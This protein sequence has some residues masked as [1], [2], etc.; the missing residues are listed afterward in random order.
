MNELSPSDPE[1]TKVLSSYYDLVKKSI[2]RQD[3]EEFIGGLP[4]TLLRRHVINLLQKSKTFSGY[5]KYT[6]T[7]KV[8]GT[9]LL[10]F[11]NEE[12]PNDSSRRKVHF[13]DRSLKIYTLSNKEKHYLN[14]V[15]GPKMLLDGEL[16]FFKNN[17]SNYYLPPSETDYLSFMVFDI[18]YGPISIKI[19]DSLMDKIPK[20]GSAN[21]MSGPVGGKQWNY[22]RRYFILKNLILPTENNGRFP[23]LAM[24]FC[25]SKFF[26]IE[27]KQILYISELSENNVVDNINKKLFAYRKEYFDFL[28]TKCDSK[29]LNDKFKKSKLEF[30]GLIFTPIDT[31]YVTDNWNKFM[32][33]QYKWKPPKEQTIDFYVKN[34]GKIVKLKGQVRDYRVVELYVLSRGRLQLFDF[35]GSSE[36]L[37]DA[38]Y[39]VTD[40][41]IAEFG[42]SDK[43]RKFMFNRLRL[44][45]DKPNAWRTAET[46]KESILYPVN[47]NLLPSAYSGDLSSIAVLASEYATPNQ[48]N[49]LLLCTNSLKFLP[50]TALETIR[51]MLDYKKQTKNAEVEI[52]IG[53]I[54][55]KYFNT[56]VS[57]NKYIDTNKL[58][59]GLNWKNSIVNYVDANLNSVRTRYKFVP[60]IGLVK[61]ES[62]VKE[63]IT[64][65]DI[66]LSHLGSFDIRIANS[67]EKEADQ[68]VEF[69]KATRITEKRRI[70]YMD[71]NG[72]IRVD[73][74]EINI[75]QFQDSKI[76]RVG[77]T[78]FQIEFEV[79]SENMSSILKFL[80]FYVTEIETTWD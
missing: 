71:P 8:D 69:D 23:P 80:E 24:E 11:I 35:E 32:N 76:T 75:A 52:R 43:H 31:E 61:L 68:T 46:V 3:K 13:I 2:L 18:L 58:F 54:K 39:I 51:Q 60:N 22:A 79:L 28:N 44:D 38:Q 19:E 27:L 48:R 40:G 77:N 21:S 50:D 6:V 49:R 67:L 33:T 10:M 41:T 59:D 63:P 72:V 55:G 34:T 20:Y 1:Y 12:D 26:R 65:I 42:F 14:S 5:S 45:K 57:L 78:E 64:K 7:S 4:I 29:T 70:S 53:K 66:N 73:L 36:G 25:E 17:Q 9:R 37:V 16:V 30:D 62:I 47:I 15:K 74:T 56:G